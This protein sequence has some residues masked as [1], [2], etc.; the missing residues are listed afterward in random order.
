MADPINRDINRLLEIF[1]DTFV[2]LINSLLTNYNIPYDDIITREICI[3][4]I[5]SQC[6]LIIR[7]GQIITRQRLID[8]TRQACDQFARPIQLDP[9]KPDN[10]KRI[11]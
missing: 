1:E 5:Y 8:V 10:K 3:S 4:W 7:S 11:N 2:P 9:T 6:L